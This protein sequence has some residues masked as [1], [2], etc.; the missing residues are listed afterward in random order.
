MPYEIEWEHHGAI[1][2]FTGEVVGRELVESEQRIASHPNFTRLRYVISVYLDAQ[3]MAASA[4]ERRHL[5]AI[6]IGSHASNPR[7]RFAFATT[8]PVIRRNIESSVQE[9]EALHAMKV[10]DSFP[11]AVG[12][13]TAQD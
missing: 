2:H 9:G 13:A 4:E 10:F 6:R 1:K 8:D 3:R 7:I 12:W 11:A 5:R